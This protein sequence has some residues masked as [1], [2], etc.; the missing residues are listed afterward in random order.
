VRLALAIVLAIAWPLQP[1]LAQDPGRV[2]LVK[3][4][5]LVKFPEFVQWPEAASHGPVR[6]CI[7]GPS[8]LL[9]PLRAVAL[10]VRY[11]GEPPSVREIDRA[12]D[13]AE[14]QLVFIPG[15]RA[16][17]LGRLLKVLAGHPVLTVGDTPGF[18]ERGVHINLYTE[19]ERVRFEINRAALEASSLTASFRL[20]EMARAPTR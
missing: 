4:G 16:A 5:F 12:Q 1:L 15:D 10:Y 14:C 7:L 6:L 13:A 17:E 3:A 18:A 8:D 9:A 20:L 11:R 2:A 19:N